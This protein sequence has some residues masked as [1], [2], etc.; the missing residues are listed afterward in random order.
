M[1]FYSI[2]NY[3]CHFIKQDKTHQKFVTPKNNNN[4]QVEV[5][6]TSRHGPNLFSDCQ[7]CFAF[8]QSSQ[9]SCFNFPHSEN[10]VWLKN[11]L[12]FTSE[13]KENRLD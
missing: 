10:K 3:K 1:T 5:N 8:Y 9:F 2:L 12:A 11:G 7:L 4:N 13:M 6:E